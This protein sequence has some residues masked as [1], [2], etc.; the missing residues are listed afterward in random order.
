MNDQDIEDTLR[1]RTLIAQHRQ[2]ISNAF[3]QKLLITPKD[4]KMGRHGGIYYISPAGRKLYLNRNQVHQLL[5]RGEAPAGCQ[6]DLCSMRK[7]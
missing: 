7:R 1:L 5:H 2:T 6:G 4:L 3:F